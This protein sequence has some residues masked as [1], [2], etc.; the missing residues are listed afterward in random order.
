MKWYYFAWDLMMRM[1]YVQFWKHSYFVWC[2]DVNDVISFSQNF[3]HSFWIIR[4]FFKNKRFIFLEYWKPKLFFPFSFQAT[5]RGQWRPWVKSKVAWNEKG[6]KLY[7]L[8]FIIPKKKILV[9]I[10]FWCI[11]Q[12]NFSKHEN[13]LYYFWWL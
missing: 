2:D 10:K 6:G 13:V 7:Q 4:K 3:I 1:L 9:W 12:D 11:Y 5:F 8:S